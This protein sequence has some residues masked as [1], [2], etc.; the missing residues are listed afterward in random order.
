MTV[1]SCFREGRCRR[2]GPG[3][4]PQVPTLFQTSVWGVF[5]SE[6]PMRFVGA[7]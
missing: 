6:D 1:D 7:F 3:N 4:S 5:P 2:E